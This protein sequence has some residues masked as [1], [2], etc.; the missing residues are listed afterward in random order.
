RALAASGVAMHP[1]TEV[2]EVRRGADGWSLTTS[3]GEIRAAE[4]V[5]ATNGYTGAATPWLR[6]RIVPIPAYMIATAPLPGEVLD[7][8]LPGR[9]PWH[10]SA[11]DMAYARISPD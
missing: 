3:R 1:G 2:Q 9:R 4:L 10:D 5:V 7:R 6:R 8:A 11:R